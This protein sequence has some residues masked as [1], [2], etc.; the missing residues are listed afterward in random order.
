[1]WNIIIVVDHNNISLLSAAYGF[2]ISVLLSFVLLLLKFLK[3]QLSQFASLANMSDTQ[4]A[5]VKGVQIHLKFGLNALC[6]GD[7]A[8]V[9]LVPLGD[10]R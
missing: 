9:S 2:A 3:Q 7:W 1:M 8:N 10:N 5:M 4:T 6:V